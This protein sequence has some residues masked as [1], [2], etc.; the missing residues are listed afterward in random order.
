MKQLVTFWTMFL[1]LTS[2]TA[3]GQT[4]KITA[5]VGATVI[6]GTGR[7]PINDA[8]ILIEGTR[9]SRVGPRSKTRIPQ[10]AVTIDGR[11]KYVIPGLA[12]MHNHLG[13]GTFTIGLGGAAV[14][15][16]ETPPDFKT[17][18]RRL[19][20]W[21]FTLVFDPGL[22]SLDSL[23]ELK[24]VSEP[25]TSAYPHFF[26]TGPQFGAKGG[27]GANGGYTP[28]QPEDARAAVRQ[29]KS[30]GVDAVKFMYTD[31]I[32]VTKQPRPMLKPEVMEAII[33]E[34]HK[35]GLKVY[36][37]A[38]VLK[39]A[40]ATLRSGADG[41]AHAILSD[42]VDAEFI[43]LMKKNHAAYITTHA[44][45]EAVANIGS[46]ARRESTFDEIGLI[47]KQVY[48]VGMSPE[49]V[50]QWESRWD[51]LSYMRERLP[52]MRS[53][54]RRVWDAGI[55]VV[56]GS[57]TGNSGA[58]VLLG[59]ASQLELQL[60]VESGLTTQEVLRAATLN[61]AKMV[62]R[63]KDLGTIERG[64]LADL[65]ILDA[66]P[67]SDIG[68]VRRIYRIIKGGAVYEQSAL[69]HEPH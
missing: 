20:G 52:V 57:D 1:T 38:P 68:N 37:H 26:S 15:P 55:L 7:A 51:N 13:E 47:P 54:L 69:L 6:D 10:T 31:L 66:D 50:N 12:D 4:G 44:I 53:N 39:Y 28:D 49:T 46:W 18:L 30:A 61:A 35:Q 17:N 56:A 58:G 19:L 21:G 65:L 43:M 23:A 41:M 8:V 60:L 25:D 16:G 3:N 40:K 29:L 14:R 27:H 42:P 48:Q 9:I 5:I 11:G 36:V 32:Y 59:L 2:I 45:F 33:D 22:P 64:K 63:D 62:G 24:R 67:L 34:A